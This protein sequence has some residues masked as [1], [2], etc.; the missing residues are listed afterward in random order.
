MSYTV[1]SQPSIHG[2]LS[3]ALETVSAY[4]FYA[5]HCALTG[6]ESIHKRK[7]FVALTENVDDALELPQLAVPLFRC[8]R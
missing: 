7:V 1:C 5:N 4:T 8:N 2:H 6:C 3:L